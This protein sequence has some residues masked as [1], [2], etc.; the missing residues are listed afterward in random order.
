MPQPSPVSA[1]PENQ[2]TPAVKKAE[3]QTAPT[4]A[5]PTPV[6]PK[7]QPT[8]APTKE[9]TTVPTPE[10]KMEPTSVKMETPATAAST[11]NKLETTLTPTA[12]KV[13][14][15]TGEN[16]TLA[17]ST[18]EP[19]IP[20]IAPVQQTV[21]TPN[22]EVP[23][24]D[25]PKTLTVESKEKAVKVELSVTEFAQAEESK[26]DPPKV[27]V[28]T[29]VAA[30]SSVPVTEATVALTSPIGAEVAMDGGVPGTETKPEFS[31]S[32][33]MQPDDQ[34]KLTEPIKSLQHVELEPKSQEPQLVL[35]TEP[36]TEADSKEVADKLVEKC[37]DVTST[38]EP[39]PISTKNITIKVRKAPLHK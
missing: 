4:K 2:A 23:N 14:P 25:V 10:A 26:P 22:V 17:A 28:E 20:T 11:Q 16:Q 13:L 29:D 37:I 21:V 30:A 5:E 24:T 35:E 34:I 9:V 33:E 7:S 3:P 31:A 39:Q 36:L 18:T 1:K 19:I 12:P 6:A 27:K 38:P 32:A 8:H 15:I